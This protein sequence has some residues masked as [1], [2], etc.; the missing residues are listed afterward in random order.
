M[1]V[2]GNSAIMPVGST[3]PKREG[4]R[5]KNQEERGNENEDSRGKTKGE[6]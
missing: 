2:K 4:K 1:A 3:K 5:P 6:K